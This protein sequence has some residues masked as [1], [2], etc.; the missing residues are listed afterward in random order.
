MRP[1]HPVQ[2][3]L[4]LLVLSALGRTVAAQTT[5]GTLI[6]RNGR[7]DQVQVEV[8][9]GSSDCEANTSVGTRILTRDQGWAIVSE[10]VIC[11]RREVVP[12]DA[13]TGWT[14]WSTTRV[15]AAT[16]REVTL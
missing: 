11:W 5:G 3:L 14:S 6:L 4:A 8:R 7:F 9:L 1:M 2:F 13:A 10:R 12:G 16:K 15:T